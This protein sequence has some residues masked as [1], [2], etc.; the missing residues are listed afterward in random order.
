MGYPHHLVNII[1]G[2]EEKDISQGGNN[3]FLFG[4]IVRL[5]LERKLWEMVD[6]GEQIQGQIGLPEPNLVTLVQE[7]FPEP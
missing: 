4:D 7:D 5:A 6:L 1:W 3:G 2:N